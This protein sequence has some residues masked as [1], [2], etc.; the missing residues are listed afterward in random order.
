[1]CELGFEAYGNGATAGANGFGF[2]DNHLYYLGSE[3][4]YTAATQAAFDEEVAKAKALIEKYKD[5]TLKVGSEDLKKGIINSMYRYMGAKDLHPC[6]TKSMLP[7]I[8]TL[9]DKQNSIISLQ[10]QEA[11]LELLATYEVQQTGISGTGIDELPVATGVFNLSG[12]KVGNSLE[13][14]KGL[15][16]GI[17]I[18]N[19]KKY[20]VK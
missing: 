2:G 6:E 20:L 11:L 18:V 15:G 8:V 17:Y 9:Q 10:E 16:K 3:S 14:L 7:D 5:A 12:L 4:A 19:G 13:D 1:M